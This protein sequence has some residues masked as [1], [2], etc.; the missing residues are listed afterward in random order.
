MTFSYK[1][2]SVKSEYDRGYTPCLLEIENGFLT[3]QKMGAVAGVAGGLVGLIAYEHAKRTNEVVWIPL[4]SITAVE[5]EST[6][7]AKRITVRAIGFP[8]YTFG[9]SK[10]EM[11]AILAL[12]CGQGRNTPEPPGAV[13]F[14]AALPVY[15]IENVPEPK[16][17]SVTLWITAGAQS[18]ASFRFQEGQTVTLGRDPSRCTLALAEYKTI[19][20]CHCCLELWETGLTVTD[21]GSTNGTWVNGVR[22]QPNQPT[23]VPDGSE[24]WLASKNCTLQVEFN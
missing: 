23:A 21:L 15:P 10:K 6:A 5:P 13:P 3:F 20:G 12:L 2:I 18:G 9:C 19:S 14:D 11:K 7:F 22:L 4:S 16:P 24:L 17:R 1:Q 8:A